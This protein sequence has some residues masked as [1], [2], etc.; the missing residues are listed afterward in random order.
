MRISDWSSD[1]CSSDLPRTASMPFARTASSPC[2]SRFRP[3]KRFSFSLQ[4]FT[5]RIDAAPS[6]SAIVQ[7]GSSSMSGPAEAAHTA[8]LGTQTL[9]PHGCPKRLTLFVNILHPNEITLLQLYDRYTHSSN[10]L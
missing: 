9:A 10:M 1:V 5:F 4:N 7:I 8:E 3:P 2:F 6:I